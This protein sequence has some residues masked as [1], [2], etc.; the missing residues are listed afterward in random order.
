MAPLAPG[1]LIV[2]VGITGY[3]AS[4]TGLQALKAGYRVRGTV[5]SMA[6]AEELR[7]AYKKEGVDVGPAKLTYVT[8]DD[9]MSELQYEAA[10]TGADGVIHPALP[11]L[12]GEDLVN[13]II[14]STLIP[15]RAAAKVGIKRFVL[16]G[17]L[18][19]VLMPGVPT[20]PMDRL[21][22][23]KDWNDEAMAKYRNA[24]EEE[25][26]SPY[27]FL[28]VYTAGKTMAEREAWKYMDNHSPPFELTVTIPGMNWGPTLLASAP[29]SLSWLAELL[30]GTD[31]P[32]SMP[33]LYIVDV[34]DDGKLHVLA[35]SAPEAAGKRIWAAAEPIDWNAILAILRKHY[36]DQPIPEDIPTSSINP[37]PWRVD[38]SLS[39]KLLGGKWIGMEECIMD[40]AQSLGY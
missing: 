2:I 10:F 31:T 34:R 1:S 37:C 3:I 14:Q 19:A 22:T 13:K 16:T 30:T 33:P 27:F 38:N 35:L 11:D 24:T 29:T 7:A 23:D 26:K 8:L 21:I 40:S 15:M 28:Y 25:K 36:P 39:T 17:T 9:L 12:Y 6:K 32:L 5:R 4:H 18:V 20:I